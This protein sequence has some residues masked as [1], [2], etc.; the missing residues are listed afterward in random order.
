MSRSRLFLA[1]IV[2]GISGTTIAMKNDDS[3][4]LNPCVS[5]LLRE[6]TDLSCAHFSWDTNGKA[7]LCVA[8]QGKGK[9]N[10]S[11]DYTKSTCFDSIKSK[12]PQEKQLV[13][14]IKNIFD[15]C[16]KGYQLSSQKKSTKKFTILGEILF[17]LQKNGETYFVGKKS[18]KSLF[19]KNSLTL[20]EL[21]NI[22]KSS[23]VLHA[24][25]H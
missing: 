12:T 25:N 19:S 22:D 7:S 8:L 1:F 9:I 3:S 17:T 24:L 2:L 11:K 18:I 20:F 16:I 10:T 15:G 6:H 5:R 14:A 4:L 23:P 21:I 13:K